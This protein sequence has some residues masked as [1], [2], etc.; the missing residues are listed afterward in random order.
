MQKGLLASSTAGVA[1]L[2]VVP[3]GQKREPPAQTCLPAEWHTWAEGLERHPGAKAGWGRASGDLGLLLLV[4][5]L[6]VFSVPHGSEPF[7]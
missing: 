3:S 1:D 7:T 6:P 2:S 5:L 4:P